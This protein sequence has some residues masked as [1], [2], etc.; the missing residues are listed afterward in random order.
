MLFDNVNN[1]QLQI[2]IFDMRSKMYRRKPY[3]FVRRWQRYSKCSNKKY[4]RWRIQ[5]GAPGGPPPLTDQNFLNFMQF[6][7]ENLA[8]L[9]VGAPS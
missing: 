8:N 1:Q 9:Y 6:F 5:G 2:M 3:F 4:N 7:G